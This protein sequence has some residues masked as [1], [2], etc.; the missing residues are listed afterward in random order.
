MFWAATADPFLPLASRDNAKIYGKSW[1]ETWF[2]GGLGKTGPFRPSQESV[3]TW[4]GYVER[5]RHI[6][7]DHA[8][9]RGVQE[10]RRKRSFAKGALVRILFG[11]GDKQR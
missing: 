8:L 6:R 2:C 10:G 11:I 9:E 1:V 3:N 4:Y 7:A 5:L